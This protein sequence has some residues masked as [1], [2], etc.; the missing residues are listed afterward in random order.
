M[1][2]WA[3]KQRSTKVWGANF[4]NART[5][6]S[7]DQ[8]CPLSSCLAPGLLLPACVRLFQHRVGMLHP[9]V[10]FTLQDTA[11]LLG[12]PLLPSLKQPCGKEQ[13]QGERMPGT[14]GTIGSVFCSDFSLARSPWS[15]FPGDILSLDSGPSLVPHYNVFPHISYFSPCALQHS[16]HLP[17]E[18]RKVTEFLW[19]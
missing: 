5:I 15:Q 1:R 17:W 13:G 3:F 10:G 4:V 16:F 6:P 7:E 8:G 11:F 12:M 14:E 18:E 2:T 9:G 19:K